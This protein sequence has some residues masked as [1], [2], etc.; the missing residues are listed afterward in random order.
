MKP[1]RLTT[2]KAQR[3]AAG[4]TINELARKANVSERTIVELERLHPSV[5]GTTAGTCPEHIA[6]RIADALGVSTAT[7]GRVAL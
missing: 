4:L 3:T 1:V 6:Q 5:D 7:I 2:L